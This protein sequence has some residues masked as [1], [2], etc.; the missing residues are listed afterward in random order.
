MRHFSSGTHRNEM[1]Y[2]LE[3]GEGRTRNEP[4]LL[5]RFSMN[6]AS[7]RETFPSYHGYSRR[8]R[9]SSTPG[10]CGAG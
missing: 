6:S 7:A 10:L 1:L 3:S 4:S 9:S 2:V 8:P 5:V